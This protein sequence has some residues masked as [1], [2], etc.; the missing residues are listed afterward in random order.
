M[1]FMD[2]IDKIYNYDKYY[3]RIT[4]K[5]LYTDTDSI[6]IK[7][8]NEDIND[9]ENVLDDISN[10]FSIITNS[11]YVNDDKLK[12]KLKVEYIIDT[13][14]ILGKKMYFIIKDDNSIDIV[15]LEGKKETFS[16]AKYILDDI[17]K[18][19]LECKNNKT[20]IYIED[21]IKFINKIYNNYYEIIDKINLIWKKSHQDVIDMIGFPINISKSL[22]ELRA[23]SSYYRGVIFFD[24]LYNKKFGYKYWENNRNSRGYH[25]YIRLKDSN[26]LD[27]KYVYSNYNLIK[28]YDIKDIT[29]PDIMTNNEQVMGYIKEFIDIDIDEY[30]LLI[31]QKVSRLGKILSPFSDRIIN[32]SKK[33][34]AIFN[35]NIYIS[36]DVKRIYDNNKDIKL[37]EKIV[38]YSE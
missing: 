17:I 27:P 22:D 8:N 11:K 13:M 4:D 38:D 21:G 20:S 26:L 15:G 25:L 7:Y 9:I 29:I 24:Y 10:R 18:F 3:D 33:Y 1:E 34:L 19:L 36:K 12:Y 2:Y 23:F 35:D 37:N 14:V 16:L 28:S 6:F 31:N 30:K 32:N 5:I